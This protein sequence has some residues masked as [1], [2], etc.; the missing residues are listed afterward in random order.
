MFLNDNAKSISSE[1]DLYALKVL[2]GITG[3]GISLE[4]EKRKEVVLRFI[5]DDIKETIINYCNIE[6][7]P[8]ELKTTVYKMV[9]D[10]YRAEN[11]G[12]ES[13][14]LG[15]ITSIKEGEV[16]INYSTTNTS[17]KNTIFK[18]YKA[19]LNKYRKLVW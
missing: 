16:S 17:L 3:E 6:E 10:M 4:E 7:V 2:L 18:D 14:A 9:I 13:N 11:L 5:L 1:D 8:D 12:N 19:K 15:N